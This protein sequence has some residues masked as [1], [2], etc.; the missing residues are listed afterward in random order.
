MSPDI[1]PYFRESIDDL[2]LFSEHD[3]E[4]AEGFRWLDKEA[5]R[6]KITFYEMA[7][8]VLHRYDVDQKAKEWM[9]KK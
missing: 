2:V 1:T 8:F 3:P 6:R 5:T 4:L 9:T 7:Y